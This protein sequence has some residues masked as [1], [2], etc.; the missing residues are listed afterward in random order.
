MNSLKAFW[1]WAK[2]KWASLPHQVQAAIVTF[3]TVAGATLV[4]AFDDAGG[5]SCATWSCLWGVVKIA[6]SPHMISTAVFAGAAALKLFY[7]TPSRRISLPPAPD[8]PAV[9]KAA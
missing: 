4:H 5:R 3:A 6:T 2:A 8:P 9:P 1:A 7:M